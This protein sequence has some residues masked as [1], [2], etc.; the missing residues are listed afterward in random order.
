MITGDPLTL[1]KSLKGGC[2]QAV[3]QSLLQVTRNRTRWKGLK[4]FQGR[5][6]QGIRKKIIHWKGGQA[7]EQAPQESG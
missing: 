7:L 1:Y 6:S 5:Y 3:D 4:L 2:S